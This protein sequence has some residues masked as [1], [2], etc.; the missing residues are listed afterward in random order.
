VLMR[1]ETAAKAL[2]TGLE[3]VGLRSGRV[4]L[5]TVWPVVADWW[6]MPVTDVA[7]ENDLCECLLSLAPAVHHPNATIFAG[8]P[9]REIAGQDLMSLEFSRGRAGLSV[10]YQ[11]GRAWNASGTA[12][13]G[14]TWAPR[15][16]TSTPRATDELRS[17]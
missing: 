9:P 11:A 1:R 7:P 13:N 2:L 10:W 5:P 14:S 6:R 8:S 4:D 3:R 12:R 17:A 16:R 15:R